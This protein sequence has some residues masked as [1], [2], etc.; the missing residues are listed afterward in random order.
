M[1]PTSPRGDTVTDR[2]PRSPPAPPCP[3]PPLTD[4]SSQAP[5]QGGERLPAASPSTSAGRHGVDVVDRAALE[6]DRLDLV[7]L[8]INNGHSAYDE[9]TSESTKYG[10]TSLNII[11]VITINYS[12][13]QPPLSPPLPP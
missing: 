12:V 13:S 2:P 11:I 6:D 3:G 4:A 7:E 10:K 1:S 8:D 5:D 9:S